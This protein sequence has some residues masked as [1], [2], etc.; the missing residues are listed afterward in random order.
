MQTSELYHIRE[1]SNEKR[2]IAGGENEA[3]CLYTERRIKKPLTADVP[4]QWIKTEDRIC[5]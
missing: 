3:L 1:K 5:H 2:E 4:K